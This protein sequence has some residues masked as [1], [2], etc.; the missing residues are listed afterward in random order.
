MYSVEEGK[1][2]GIDLGY[3]NIHKKVPSG[4]GPIYSIFLYGTFLPVSFPPIFDM[5]EILEEC[6]GD[7]FPIR[8]NCEHRNNLLADLTIF[9][10]HPHI[11]NLQIWEYQN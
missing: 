5:G 4:L 3:N 9:L 2:R 7:S 1:G 11:S 10:R 8:K 6:E